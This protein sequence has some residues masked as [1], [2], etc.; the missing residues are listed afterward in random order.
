MPVENRLFKNTKQ[1]KKKTMTKRLWVTGCLLMAV[2]GLAAAD[3]E[4]YYTNLPTEVQAVVKVEI[5]A[6]VVTLTDCGAVG[7]GVTLC[8]EA[9]EKGIGIHGSS[10]T[11]TMM[12]ELGETL[13]FAAGSD[14]NIKLTT[15]D[16]LELFKAYLRAEQER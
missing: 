13:H 6:N 15:K 4:K 1:S 3:Y 14:R 9:F 5:P 7:D 11:N 12:V 8:T 16:D 2:L 10:Y